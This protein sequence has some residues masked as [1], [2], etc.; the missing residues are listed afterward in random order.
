MYH[1]QRLHNIERVN[2]KDS[3]CS[4]QISQDTPPMKHVVFEDQIYF[5]RWTSNKLWVQSFE[6]AI[7]VTIEVEGADFKCT[8]KPGRL[9]AELYQADSVAP[10]MLDN[11][12][13]K[14]QSSRNDQAPRAQ[15]L[16]IMRNSTFQGENAQT[17]E[18]PYDTS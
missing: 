8:L 1:L 12:R 15:S 2:L 6:R 9:H 18:R 13:L 10:K 14:F 4:V 17:T 11:V 16:F 7:G 3:E 5:I